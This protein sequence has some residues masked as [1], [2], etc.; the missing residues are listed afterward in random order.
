MLQGYI[1]LRAIFAES[2]ESILTM[3]DTDKNEQATVTKSLTWK[4][5]GLHTGAPSKVTIAPA[6]P[7][8]GIKFKRVDLEGANWINADIRNVVSTDRSTTIAS[9]EQ[10]IATVEHILAALHG[11][12]ISNA[13][14]HVDGPEIPIL[15]GNILPFFNQLKAHRA[16]EEHT[17]LKVWKLDEVISFEDEDSGA[18]YILLPSDQLEVEVILTYENVA[19]G[20][21]HASYK[22]GDDFDAFANAR[23]F[24]LSS[25]LEELCER[26]LLKGGNLNNAVVVPSGPDP[27]GALM[28]AL[29]HLQ[30]AD[31]EEIM[32][33]FDAGYELKTDNELARHKLVDLLGDLTLLGYQLKAK[34]IAK[35]PGHTGNTALVRHL[36]PMLQKTIKLKGKPVYDPSAEPVYDSVAIQDYLPHRYPF[37]LVDKIIELSETLVVGIKNITINES[38]F[39]G[40]FPGNPV[41]PGVLQMEAL[42]QTG[43]LLALNNVANPADWDTY[44]LKMDNVKFKRKVLPGDTLILKME[45]LTP[46]RRGIVHMQGTAYVGDHIVSE[47]ELTAQIV[48]RT[49]L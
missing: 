3:R 39:Q 18:S 15:D 44:F 47:G 25:E 23:T 30:R 26:G 29:D 2:E 38:L 34:I 20:R 32:R 17:P 19:I 10:S 11:S 22:E 5:I 14:I 45:L 21:Q 31:S 43:G 12:G 6:G 48:D 27:R 37:L 36:K 4:G 13:E 46:I 49:T 16:S 35:K 24:V 40:H 41:F 1:K 9:G 42:A 33:Q 7:N 28:N 8:F